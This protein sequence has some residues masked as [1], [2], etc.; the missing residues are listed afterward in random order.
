MK[1][2]FPRLKGARSR[3]LAKF[4]LALERERKRSRIYILRSSEQFL[5]ASASARKCIWDLKFLEF[6]KYFRW[7]NIE[8]GVFWTR[9]V[10]KI[11]QN[12][13]MSKKSFAVL[14]R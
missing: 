2:L 5:S 3:A 1:D 4:N 14:E 12:S 7:N 8:N 13:D 10:Q 9:L 11:T 6:K